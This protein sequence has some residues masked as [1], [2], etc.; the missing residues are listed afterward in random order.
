MFRGRAFYRLS[1]GVEAGSS[2]FELRGF[3]KAAI[4]AP[5]HFSKHITESHSTFS[6]LA[7]LKLRVAR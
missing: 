3:P 7:A 6:L 5:M 4:F 2:E 1:R